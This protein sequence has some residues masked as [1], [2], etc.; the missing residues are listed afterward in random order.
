MD[1]ARRKES[2]VA[3]SPA[4]TRSSSF[5]IEDILFSKPKQLC[6][7]YPG[8]PGLS[9]IIRPSFP[10][11]YTGYH[12]FPAAPVF[13]PHVLQHVQGLAAKH[14]E[15]PFMT[16]T[17]AGFPLGP[18]FQHHSPGK[19][20][21]RRKARTVF[22]DQQLNGLEKRFESQ[23]Y[24]STPERVELASQLSLSE[25]QVKTWFQN[26]RMKHKKMQ[27][28]GHEDDDSVDDVNEDSDVGD[29]DRVKQSDEHTTEKSSVRFPGYDVH[30]L[31]PGKHVVNTDT[32]G[33]QSD[34]NEEIDVV[35]S[36]RECT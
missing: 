15:H 31:V 10:A 5:F 6:R 35:E 3:S 11:E 23:R 27:K 7:D 29:D 22:S 16:S 21:R 32:S 4:T 24:L 2:S 28:K 25:T 9:A 17:S 30:S 36:D 14:S 1:I 19:H 13:F 18:L 8:L 26:R 33:Y 20:C 12:C 34:D